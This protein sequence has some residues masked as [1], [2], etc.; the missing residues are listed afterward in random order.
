MLHIGW[1]NVKPYFYPYENWG[2]PENIDARL[3]LEL[4]NLRRF[5]NRKVFI[6]CGYEFREKSS[7]HSFYRAVDFHIENMHPVD[8]FL[9]VS[10]FDAF[11]GIGCYTWWSRHG[12]TVGGVHVDT[13]P[14]GS[15]FNEDAR[16]MSCEKGSYTALTRA[17]ICKP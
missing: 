11:N 17:G 9:A 6:H 1:E 12:E 5:V 4:F 2:D 15:R 3:V 13:R 14:H 7:W 10:R 16:W 8:Q